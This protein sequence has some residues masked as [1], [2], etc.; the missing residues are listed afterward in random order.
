ML[1]RLALPLPLFSSPVSA[2]GAVTRAIQTAQEEEAETMPPLSS[3]AGSAENTPAPEKPNLE[4]VLLSVWLGGSVIA[5]VWFGAVNVKLTMQLRR[6]RQR[7]EYAAPVPIYRA[8]GLSSPCLYGLFHPS[9]YLTEQAVNDPQKAEIAVAHE[10]MHWHHRD[11][12]WS[13]VRILCLTAY[14]FDPFVWLAAWLSK[15]DGELFCDDGTIRSLGEERRYEYGRTLLEMTASAAR[16]VDL[17]CFASTMSGGARRMRERI[18]AI[19]HR[20]VRSLPV[21]A[22]LV[23]VMLAAAACTF[24]GSAESVE[25]EPEVLPTSP[26]WTGGESVSKEPEILTTPIPTPLPWRGENGVT[27]E[28]EV[29]PTPWPQAAETT[30]QEEPEVLPTPTPANSPVQQGA[31]VEETSSGGGG[32]NPPIQWVQTASGGDLPPQTLPP[33]ETISPGDEAAAPAA[34]PPATEAESADTDP[35]IVRDMRDVYSIPDGEYPIDMPSTVPD[36]PPPE[37][38]SDVR[39]EG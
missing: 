33:T 14:W 34:T 5:A 7:L 30:M 3:Y 16:P 39:E 36:S 25:A 38:Y 24:A 23:V 10:L 4:Q 2:A 1:L 32:G 17:R 6:G 8:D 21:I 19:V 12:L 28:P 9:I 29:L 27:E 20:P 18:A 22:A 31:A 26:P 11:H 35:V 13:F 15:Q 37:S